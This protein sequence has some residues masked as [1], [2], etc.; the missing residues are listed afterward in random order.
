MTER[1]W[2]ENVLPR[3]LRFMEFLD[4]REMPKGNGRVRKPVLGMTDAIRRT[5]V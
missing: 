5:G 2:D 3:F 1:E 4:L